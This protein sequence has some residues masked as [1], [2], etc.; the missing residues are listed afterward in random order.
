MLKAHRNDYFCAKC[1]LLVVSA[2][3]RCPELGAKIAAVV[4]YTV[5][6]MYKKRLALNLQ[7]LSVKLKTRVKKF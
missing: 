6:T 4:Y 7:I 5:N 1:Y 3:A 2:Y